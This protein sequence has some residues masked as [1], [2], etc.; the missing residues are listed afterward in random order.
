MICIQDSTC[1]K[2]EFSITL[3][4]TEHKKVFDHFDWSSKDSFSNKEMSVALNSAKYMT[5]SDNTKSIYP[6]WWKDIL[7]D[8]LG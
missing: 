6:K 8:I 1:G 4:P 3:T 7:C 2:E 5:S